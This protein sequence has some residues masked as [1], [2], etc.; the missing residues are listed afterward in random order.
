MLLRTWLRISLL[1]VIPATAWSLSSLPLSAPYAAVAIDMATIEIDGLLTEPDWEETS[2][3]S[4][5]TQIL[6]ERGGQPTERT[7]VKIFHDAD[8]L[9]IGARLHHSQPEGVY[10]S[11]MER[12]QVMESDDYFAVIIDTYNDGSSALVFQTNPL[13]TRTD[14]ELS[15]LGTDFGQNFSWNAFWEAKSCRT[16]FGWSTE[17]RIPLFTLR[18]EASDQN[19]MGFKFI[20]NIRSKSERLLL[21]FEN[22]ENARAE[23]SLQSTWKITLKGITPKTPVFITP[24]T[25]AQMNQM[26]ELNGDSSAYLTTASIYEGKGYATR[27]ALDRILSNHGLDFKLLMRGSH[28]LDI[29]LN[30]DFAQA[31]AD[32]RILNLSRFSVALPEKRPFFLENADLLATQAFNHIF[33]HS[34]QIGIEEDRSVPLVL[35]ARLTGMI[36]EMQYGL[37]NI[38]SRGLPDL[39][40][41]PKNH[42][43]LRMKQN[44]R[45]GGNYLAGL[46]TNTT[47]GSEVNQNTLAELDGLIHLSSNTWTS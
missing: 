13:G 9:Y 31:E 27:P 24:Y 47:G 20:R 44:L 34:R 28:T 17:I 32:D 25:T 38:Q 19:I 36:K 22:V 45:T 35:G 26:S 39:Q 1:L 16:E 15:D 43:V 3:L 23:L 40:I 4:E 7:E 12:D 14:Y 46:I 33:F 10:A 21:P 42:T 2:Q 30:T 8:Y 41:R 6:P 29:T 18:Y 37:L 11:V 5:F